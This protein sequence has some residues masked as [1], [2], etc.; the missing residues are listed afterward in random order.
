MNVLITQQQ[1][2]TT[3]LLTLPCENR[4]KYRCSHQRC[5]AIKG[6][7]RSFAKF[8]RKHLCQSLFFKKE[9][10]AQV[11]FCEFYE[12][13]KNTFFTEHLGITAFAN[14]ETKMITQ[15]EDTNIKQEELP[16]NFNSFMT[17]VLII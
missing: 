4:Y 1:R 5:S 2:L 16:K 3:E 10:L 9:T 8:T 7:F 12:I 14:T 11:S 17:V 13:S 6:A 15:T